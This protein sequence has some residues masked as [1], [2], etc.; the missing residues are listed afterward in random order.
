[1]IS[2]VAFMCLHYS[3]AML[4]P[5][6]GAPLGKPLC[7]SCHKGRPLHSQHWQPLF[8]KQQTRAWSEAPL[9]A[10]FKIHEDVCCPSLAWHFFFL[11]FLFYAGFE[12]F[13]GVSSQL[14]GSQ[15]NAPQKQR[16]MCGLKSWKKLGGEEQ[17]ERER[18]KT[19]LFAQY[20]G[21]YLWQ[22][23]RRNWLPGVR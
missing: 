22:L 7:E 21:G 19:D 5:P 13:P 17:E 8:W 4:M 3:V 10:H 18:G 2:L 6:G 1:M 14:S 9:S 15:L 11:L 12:A 23:E 16:L 20:R